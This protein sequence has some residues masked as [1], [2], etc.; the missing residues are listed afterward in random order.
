MNPA[1]K[2]AMYVLIAGGIFFVIAMLSY[3]Y[4]EYLHRYER[5]RLEVIY[6][7]D[8]NACADRVGVQ[9]IACV[10][11]AADANA[12]RIESIKSSINMFVLNMPLTWITFA[13]IF[14]YSGLVMWYIQLPAYRRPWIAISA[15]GILLQTMLMVGVIIHRFLDLTR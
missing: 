5:P 2:K 14:G 3:V 8:I 15:I 1:E 9:Y 13:T 11:E 12:Q 6:G 4:A 10:Q 7:Q